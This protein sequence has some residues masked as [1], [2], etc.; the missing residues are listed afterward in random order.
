MSEREGSLFDLPDLEP[1]RAVDATIRL[2]GVNPRAWEALDRVLRGWTV[3]YLQDREGDGAAL[4]KAIARAALVAQE[5]W[6][7]RW[8]MLLDLLRDGRATP[9]MA[10]WVRLFVR[11]PKV[12]RIFRIVAPRAPL[13]R[14]NVV[15]ALKRVGFDGVAPPD[16]EL[17]KALAALEAAHLLVRRPRLANEEVGWLLTVEGRHALNLLEVR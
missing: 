8:H 4:M 15:L 3:R 16:D 14:A 6:L 9:S 11:E 5:P 17:D 2:A 1:D 12:A 10:E 7:T 13:S